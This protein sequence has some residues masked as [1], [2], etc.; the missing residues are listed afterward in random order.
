MFQWWFW[1]IS[2]TFCKQPL[3]DQFEKAA[4]TRL[5]GPPVSGQPTAPRLSALF[6]VDQAFNELRP[7]LECGA[8]FVDPSMTLVNP[9]DPAPAAAV[10]EHRLGRFEAHPGGGATLSADRVRP[11]PTIRRPRCG[12]CRRPTP[13]GFGARICRPP[14]TDL[15]LPRRL[16]RPRQQTD[17]VPELVA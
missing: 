8:P 9:D 15:Q 5:V 12:D 11:L 7:G 6:R 2:S 1:R 17:V 16:T 14:S 3:F 4:S 13:F 10:I